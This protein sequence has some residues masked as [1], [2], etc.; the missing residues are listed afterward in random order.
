MARRRSDYDSPWK[1]IIEGFFPQFI[2]F[3]FP[4]IY[5][6]IDWGKGYEFLDKEL[7]KVVRR[8][9]TGRGYVDKLVKVYR[10]DGTEEWLL[11][12]IEV[13]SQVEEGF[14]E[15]MYIYSYRIF[16]R[17]KQKVISL[18]L[19]ADEDPTWRPQSYGYSLWGY[20]IN[21]EFP[22][23]KLLDYAEQWAMLQ[24]SSNPFA[25]AVMVHLK[26]QETRRYPKSRLRWKIELVKGMYA[27]GWGQNHIWGLFRFLD[28]M[29]ELS[30]RYELQFEKEVA[31]I[32]ETQT[33]RFVTHI[34]RRAKAEGIKEGIE[35]GIKEGIK[36]GALQSV[37]EN[38]DEIL[39]L[40]FG[41]A[42][43][44][45]IALLNQVV[46]LQQLKALHRQAVLAGSLEEFEHF[47]ETAIADEAK[48]S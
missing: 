8:A 13:Q 35:E 42:T 34:E 19:L 11:I 14:T 3:F 16:D 45:L 7:Q 26:A 48:A 29:M 10:K 20:K 30:D 31:K 25:V 17:Y 22:I 44:E 39:T 36:E 12:H 9:K 47:A 21:M 4:L 23:V 6:E 40:R 15:R 5:P 18:A 46:D 41:T 2:A 1:E 24:S 38:I 32:E 27:K 28:W 43:E 37:R 33:M